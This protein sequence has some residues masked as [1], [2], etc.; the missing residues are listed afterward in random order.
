MLR[1]AEH[2]AQDV[3]ERRIFDREVGG[4]ERAEQVAD[5]R[6]QLALYARLCELEGGAGASVWRGARRAFLW[7]H[8]L[9]WLP[10]YL[11]KLADVA[12]PFYRGWGELLEEA[13]LEEEAAVGPQEELPLALR[14]APP[15]ADPREAAP[16]E[17]I[18]SLLAPARAGM[19]LVRAD[20][21]RAARELGLGLRAGERR[22]ALES[23]A[24]LGC[25]PGVKPTP[26]P[27]YV[28]LG[29]AAVAALVHSIHPRASSYDRMLDFSAYVPTI[30]L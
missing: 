28:A 6:G 1:L 3:L 10:A 17:F 30:R 13:L 23:L 2:R 12:P 25:L 29:V 27:V 8:L 20:L 9:S 26:K 24:R 22:F 19:I 7:E 18:R 15:V 5:H 4:L 16:G 11:D 21:A 14:E